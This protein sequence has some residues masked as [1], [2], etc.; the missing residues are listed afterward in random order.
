MQNVEFTTGQIHPVEIFKESWELIKDQ[1]WLVFG[2]TLVGLLIGGAVPIILIGPMICGVFLIMF[3]VID[4]Q[5]IG[6]EHLFKGFDFIWKSLPVS[7]LITL[8]V[9]LLIFVIYIPIIGMA[10]AGQRMNESELMGFLVGTFVFEF[11]VIFA[12]VCFHTLLM[13][14]FPLIADRRLSAMEAV[15]LSAR[16]VWA[17]LSGIAGLFGIGMIVVF[18]GYL[19]FCIGV[20]LTIP[21][22]LM[23]Q[24][25]AYRKVF[26]RLAPFYQDHTAPNAYQ[27]LS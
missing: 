20:Y 26:P 10:V 1:Y 4:R 6:F 9:I 7:L 13:F 21:L 27:D 22:I 18:I 14:S 8:P 5:P 19:M 2:I 16:A 12:M 23:S 17:N 3:R 25:L 15:K 11:V 24:A